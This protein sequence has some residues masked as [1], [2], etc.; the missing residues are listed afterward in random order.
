MR[1]LFLLS[2]TKSEGFL[3]SSIKNKLLLAFL[4]SI[5]TISTGIFGFPKDKCAKILIQ[6]SI[7]FFKSRE[8]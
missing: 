5:P 1:N 2:G 3:K 6:E 4:I 7:K 8:S